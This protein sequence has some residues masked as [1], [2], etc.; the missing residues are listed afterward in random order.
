M[1]LILPLIF[2]TQILFAQTYKVLRASAGDNTLAATSVFFEATNDGDTESTPFIAYFPVDPVTAGNQQ[3]KNTIFST[4][5]AHPLPQ[6]TRNS[7]SFNGAFNQN[8]YISLIVN[9][10]SNSTLKAYVYYKN[11]SGTWTKAKPVSYEGD[12]YYTNTVGSYSDFTLSYKIKDLCESASTCHSDINNF[13]TDTTDST[14]LETT[15]VTLYVLMTGTIQTSST[16]DPTTSGVDDGKFVK[17]RFSSKLPTPRPSMTNINLERGDA[18]L[19][20][21]FTS[22]VLSTGTELNH[23]TLFLNSASAVTDDSS[24]LDGNGGANLPA[25]CVLTSAINS[26]TANASNC[27]LLVPYQKS[28]P[29]TV[30]NLVNEQTYDLSVAQV[31]K[32]FFTTTLSASGRGRPQEIQGFIKEQ[33]CFFLSAGFGQKHFV[34]DYFRNF[35]D[36]YLLK[37]YIGQKV[38]AFYYDF[39]PQYTHFIYQSKTNSFIVRILGYSLYFIFKF[40]FMML[41]PI[42]I[43]LGIKS[44]AWYKRSYSSSSSL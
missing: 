10:N 27:Y 38:V 31:N 6:I 9:N 43:F 42:I 29:A 30:S 37:N 26:P 13:A 33:Q 15:Y 3:I 7:G 28:G 21:N 17:V 2:S 4:N 44:R 18:Q 8:P 23:K 19:T 35:R 41:L 34:L 32:F 20:I 40:W 5:T 16:I 39:A 36:R 22:E 25:T 12:G 11:T 1:G 24:L 14:D